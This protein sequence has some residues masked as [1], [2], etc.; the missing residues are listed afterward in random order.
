MYLPLCS[1]VTES[2]IR[3]LIFLSYLLTL[4]PAT[5]ATDFPFR[6][7][8]IL[9]GL[10]PL[11]T[12]QYKEADSPA[13]RALD[14]KSKGVMCGGTAKMDFFLK[15][16][17]FNHFTRRKILIWRVLI[18][19]SSFGNDKR[20]GQDSIGPCPKTVESIEHGDLGPKSF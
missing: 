17:K 6:N 12:V 15:I 18:L 5:S 1:A 16:F 7:H 19:V 8:S 13:F 11:L 9:I 4:I 20:R 14:P 2:I 3:P 10:S